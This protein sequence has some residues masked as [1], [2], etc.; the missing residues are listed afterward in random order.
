MRWIG[1]EP[2]DC[3]VGAYIGPNTIYVCLLPMVVLRIP[4]GRR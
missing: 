3:W 2:R 1:F 4:R